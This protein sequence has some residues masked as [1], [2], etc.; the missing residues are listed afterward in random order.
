MNF[1][2]VC[3]YKPAYIL[4]GETKYQISN[5]VKVNKSNFTF[6]MVTPFNGFYHNLYA[7]NSTFDIVGFDKNNAFVLG[8]CII[9]RQ[10]VSVRRGAISRGRYITCEEAIIHG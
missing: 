2:E 1:E 6:E 8:N 4:L 7:K 3:V 10:D 5:G 9:F